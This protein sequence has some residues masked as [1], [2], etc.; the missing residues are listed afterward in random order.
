MQ[1]T[2]IFVC[3]LTRSLHCGIQQDIKVEVECRG[4]SLGARV[5][6]TKKESAHRNGTAADK[7][8]RLNIIA[9]IV[10]NHGDPAKKRHEKAEYEIQSELH[11]GDKRSRVSTI[12]KQNTVSLIFSWNSESLAPE[13]ANTRF[14]CLFFDMGPMLEQWPNVLRQNYVA[15]LS[16]ACWRCVGGKLAVSSDRT[17]S[18]MFLSSSLWT[19]LQIS[20]REE[21]SKKLEKKTRTRAAARGGER[22]EQQLSFRSV[23]FEWSGLDGMRYTASAAAGTN[24]EF[25]LRGVARSVA[26]ANPGSRIATLGKNDTIPSH[27]TATPQRYC[28]APTPYD[29]ALRYHSKFEPHFCACVQPIYVP[30]LLVVSSASTVD[31]DDDDDDGWTKSISSSTVATMGCSHPSRL[32]V[33]FRL[34]SLSSTTQP[35]APAPAARTTGAPGTEGGHRR[36]PAYGELP[37]LATP[38]QYE[39]SVTPTPAREEGETQLA[40]K[41]KR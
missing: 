28:T 26:T 41:R 30:L 37:E 38:M 31:S 29:S 9:G 24:V 14:F 10:A 16:I 1:E 25:K 23:K 12:L 15:G 22:A 2:C 18:R 13:A 7:V 33:A 6:P 36:P 8:Q 17:E 11:P 32:R 21:N 19:L 35:H 39:R 4:N 5:R 34:C 20:E 27:V 40:P 3:D